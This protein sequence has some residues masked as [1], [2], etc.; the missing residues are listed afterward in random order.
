VE[1]RRRMEDAENF[2]LMLVLCGIIQMMGVFKCWLLFLGRCNCNVVEGDQD[3]FA[4]ACQWKSLYKRLFNRFQWELWELVGTYL[5][6]WF[7]NSGWE[8]QKNLIGNYENIPEHAFIVKNK[9][10]I[11]CFLNILF[12]SKLLE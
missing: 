9:F 5:F 3:L 10:R 4:G 7:Q 6:S 8:V 11:E 2:I 1:R 12:H